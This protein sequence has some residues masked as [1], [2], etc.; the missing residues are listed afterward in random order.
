MGLLQ[1]E[2]SDRRLLDLLDELYGEMAANDDGLNT[3][4][5]VVATELESG[6]IRLFTNHPGSDVGVPP[7]NSNPLV[8]LDFLGGG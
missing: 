3:G 7:K 8:S 5:C 1:H 6:A 2:Y 4:L